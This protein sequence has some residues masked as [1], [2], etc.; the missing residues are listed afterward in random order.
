MKRLF[1]LSATFAAVLATSHAAT[2]LY[3]SLDVNWT[4]PANTASNDTTGTISISTTPDHTFT[5][6]N[7]ATPDASRTRYFGGTVTWSGGSDLWGAE[8]YFRISGAGTPNITFGVGRTTGNFWK[9]TANGGQT[10]T[11]PFS[12]SS[13]DFIIKISD[14][15][16]NEAQ[17][18]LFLDANANSVTEGT[19][20]FSI[21]NFVDAMSPNG[22]VNMSW[23]MIHE[24]WYGEATSLTTQNMFSS[25]EWVPV[26]SI[27]EPSSVALLLGGLGLLVWLR[28]QSRA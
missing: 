19:P 8:A 25:D 12:S 1:F 5:D 17:V 10:T 28:R 2:F 9:I 24:N 16:W 3:S 23:T 13:F 21:T 26:S 6:P 11:L 15:P 14:R 27:P 22:M 7:T 20:D 4:Q 18:D